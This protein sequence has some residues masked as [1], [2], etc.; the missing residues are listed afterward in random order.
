RGL[1]T[2]LKPSKLCS[3]ISVAN[4]YTCRG[5]CSINTILIF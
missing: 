4:I 1:Y 2:L 5:D 3:I